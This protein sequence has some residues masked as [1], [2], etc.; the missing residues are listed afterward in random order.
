MPHFPPI[1]HAVD[2][3]SAAERSDRRTYPAFVAAAVLAGGSPVAVKISYSELAPFWGAA[4]RF[5]I[6][7]VILAA[8]IAVLR[9]PIPRGRA[10]VG[11]LLFGL[12]QFGIPFMLIYWGLTEV[13]AGTTMVILAVVPLLTL[14]FGVAERLER[15]SVQ[16]IAGAVVALIGVGLVFSDGI[17]AASPSALLAVLG[18]A[19]SMAAAPIVI[20]KFPRV[21]AVVENALGMAVGGGLLLGLST[22]FAEPKVLPV[23]L[24]TQLAL[25]YLVLLG[26]IGVF[27]LYLFV[28]RRMSASGATYVMLLAPLAAVGLGG[29]LLGEPVRFMF[30]IGGVLVLA[31]VYVGVIARAARS[32]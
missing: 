13:T 4:L 19:L 24:R 2:E 28:L 14:I 5:L 21:H 6:A 3:P 12:L 16:G 10:L 26:S 23:D 27:L 11:V 9:L 20:K 17:G 25:A 22:I 15:L 29:L 7:F 18:G 8:V 30:L 31:G 1:H 32:R